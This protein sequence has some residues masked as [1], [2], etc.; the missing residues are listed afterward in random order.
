MTEFDR[1][2]SHIENLED[3]QKGK[4]SVLELIFD[5]RCTDKEAFQIMDQE[6]VK[7]IWDKKWRAYQMFL[8]MWMC[9]H[10]TFMCFLTVSTIEKSKH[11]F[12][13]QNNETSISFEVGVFSK[14]VAALLMVGGITYFFFFCMCIKELWRRRSAVHGGFFNLQIVT[15][16]I[17]YIL[18]LLFISVGALGES[19]LIFLRCHCDYNIIFALIS[20]WYF[21]IYFSPFRTET[22]SFVYKC[23]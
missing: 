15:H 6:L 5:S 4:I 3:S 22:V 13:F 14:R 7:F 12:L 20:G 1:L 2:I 18:C 10:I 8:L 11:Y 9:L 19:I 17:D 16:N 23:T 21:T